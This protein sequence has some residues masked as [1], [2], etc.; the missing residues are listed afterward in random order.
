[1]GD[2]SSYATRSAVSGTDRFFL[3]TGT[4]PEIESATLEMVAPTVI[5]GTTTLVGV[6]TIILET[7]TLTGSSAGTS[8]LGTATLTLGGGGGGY[9]PFV[10]NGTLTL[11]SLS[12]F[13]TS[14]VGSNPA[15]YT[16]YS[17]GPIVLEQ[18][19]QGGNEWDLRLKATP[20]SVPYTITAMIEV[21]PL[22]PGYCGQ[23]GIILQD[24]GT[25]FIAFTFTGNIGVNISR[26]D[27]QHSFDNQTT[28]NNSFFAGVV[29]LRAVVDAVHIT[30]YISS[31]GL[32]WTFIFMETVTN[33]LA[34]TPAL[35][36]FGINASNAF[37]CEFSL[38]DWHQT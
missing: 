8:A 22:Q 3:A 30:Y 36:G 29:W 4:S 7:G 34:T 15:T 38:W 5:L 13:G 17:G 23:A 1:M 35:M 6:G 20:G 32:A 24:T 16:S 28:I 2:I 26:W 21:A 27:D 19:H 18:E 33:F 9:A 11:D 31:N 12:S 14:V 10:G 25:K 37:A